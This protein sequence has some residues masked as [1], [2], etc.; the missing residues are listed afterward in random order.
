[1]SARFGLQWFAEYGFTN[2]SSVSDFL[3][4]HVSRIPR[5]SGTFAVLRE[6]PSDPRFLA[7][8]NASEVKGRDPSVSPNELSARWINGCPLLYVGKSRQLRD[9]LDRLV[10]FGSGEPVG[11]WGG[12]YLWQLANSDSLTIAW[13]CTENEDEADHLRLLILGIF[14]D[15]YGRM[16]FANVTDPLK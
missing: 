9:A 13:R 7:T 6:D 12:R 8:S 16:P 1:V 10:R 15:V 5:G 4:S 11:Y 2:S 3:W 14:K